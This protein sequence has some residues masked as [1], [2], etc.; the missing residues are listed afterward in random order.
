MYERKSLG[1]CFS[2]LA[3]QPALSA[4]EPVIN[5][6]LRANVGVSRADVLAFAAL[7]G[8]NVSQNEIDFLSRF[9][10]GRVNC[11]TAGD[12]DGTAEA[13]YRTGPDQPSDHPSP[14]LTT[15]DLTEFFRINFNFTTDQTVAIMGAHT[16]GDA[17][18]RN[19]GFN[20]GNG[21]VQNELR[22]DNDY[23]DE[24]VGRAAS[25]DLMGLA[26]SSTQLL[27]CKIYIIL[28][29]SHAPMQHRTLPI[30]AKS[31]STIVTRPCS[32]IDFS[33]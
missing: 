21:W 7:T 30:G 26:V 2:H 12:C 11:E 32:R 5:E 9:T 16:L 4:L 23:Y 1:L 27:C 3:S 29:H 33:G 19:S 10:T 31:K 6:T 17:N 24:I 15:H 18:R 14:D 20:G 25:T 28:A 8:A 13:C 22:L